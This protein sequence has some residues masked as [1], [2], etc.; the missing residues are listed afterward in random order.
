MATSFRTKPT[1]IVVIGSGA[2][3]AT[4]AYTLLLRDRANEVVLIDANQD[5]AQGDALDMSHGAPFLGG[6]KVW[7]GDYTDCEQADIVIITAGA[8]QRP[9]ETRQ[10]L[11]QRNI[12]I[13][14]DILQGVLRHNPNPILLIASNPVDVLSYATWKLS[15]LSHKRVI[16]S[17][18]VLD[19]ARFRYLIGEK[20][21][22]TPRSIHGYV[23]GEHGDSELPVWSR[24]NIVGAPIVLTDDE[25]EQLFSSTR[26]AA[27]Q[28][29]QAKGS[30]A[31]AIALALD[32]ISASILDN[33][34]GILNVST[35]IEDY[36]GISDVYLGFPTILSGGGV[37]GLV[38]IQLS[39]SELAA[40]RRSANFLKERI[41]ELNFA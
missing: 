21:G 11:L 31:Y 29:I 28:I 14:K 12:V 9:G 40:L 2:V 18:T 19:S 1:R 33:E 25:K 41:T 13:L 17:G 24:T 6:V 35:Y 8:A 37:K 26:N 7:A 20:A 27:Y 34:H 38:D 36:N 32:R 22:V 39:E 15:G 16:G 4:T 3:G 10:D 5:K 30:T 23:I